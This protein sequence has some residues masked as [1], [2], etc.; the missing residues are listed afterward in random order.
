M[1]ISSLGTIAAVTALL[2]TSCTANNGKFA[3]INKTNESISHASVFVCGQAIKFDEIQPNRNVTG[4]YEIKSDSHYLV[5]I[6]FQSG[7]KLQNEIGYVTNGMDF[8]HEISVTDTDISI[9]D[10]KAK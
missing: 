2:L 8:Q 1:K 4:S 7:K 3:L 9:A 5:R 10:I 6:E